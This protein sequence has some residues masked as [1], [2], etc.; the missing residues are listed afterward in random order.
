MALTLTPLWGI[1]GV[2]GVAPGVANQIQGVAGRSHHSLNYKEHVCSR[3]FLIYYSEAVEK[4]TT[5][6]R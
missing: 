4:R 6:A 3:Q 5:H 1:V 2:E